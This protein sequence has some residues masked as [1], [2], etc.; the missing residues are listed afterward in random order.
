MIEGSERGRGVCGWAEFE[1][2]DLAR[3]R[4]DDVPSFWVPHCVDEGGLSADEEARLC[5]CP[6]FR[7]ELE[8]LSMPE[9]RIAFARPA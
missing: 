1:D 4:E 3:G 6:R 7:P 9:R 5:R 2:G 8:C